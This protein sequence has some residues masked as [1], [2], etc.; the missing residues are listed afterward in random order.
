MFL[1]SLR[2]KVTSI[3]RARQH[4]Q[5]KKNTQQVAFFGDTRDAGRTAKVFLTNRGQ[6]AFDGAITSH[7]RDCNA[8][9]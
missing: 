5:P 2:T 6:N 9:S 7:L 1:D 8:I 3:V 4:A